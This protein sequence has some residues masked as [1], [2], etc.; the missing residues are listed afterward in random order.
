MANGTNFFLCSFL[1]FLISH[2]IFWRPWTDEKQK[3][4]A[5][6]DLRKEEGGKVP[7]M[8]EGV[9]SLLGPFVPYK[10]WDSGLGPDGTG[11]AVP[12][13]LEGEVS[14]DLALGQNGRVEPKDRLGR[15]PGGPGQDVLIHDFS[16][17]GFQSGRCSSAK[18]NP[19]GI[20]ESDCFLSGRF[21]Q[22][23]A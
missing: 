19:A 21:A 11:K 22:L 15:G 5:R 18:G 8:Q 6:S 20:Q 7:C 3:S 9:F 13:K 16:T 12:G 10:T 17:R 4:G 2:T 1:S 14:P 23:S